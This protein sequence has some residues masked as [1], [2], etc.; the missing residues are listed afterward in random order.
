MQGDRLD[1]MTTREASAWRG[2]F[3]PNSGLSVFDF[4]GQTLSVARALAVGSL[5]WPRFE[6][7]RGCVLLADRD[8]AESVDRWWD[9]LDGDRSRIE[10]VLNHVHLWD[11]FPSDD[12]FDDADAFRD[13]AQL[14]QAGWRSALAREYPHRAFDVTCS[15]LGTDDP[16]YGPTLTF[17]SSM[18]G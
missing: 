4:I 3:P 17:C 13:L 5:I 16:E 15:G 12:E 7:I 6:E 11:V 2:S 8:M 9:Q 1:P 14:M 18:S 10:N